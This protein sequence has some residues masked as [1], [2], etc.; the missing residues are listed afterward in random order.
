MRYLS[1]GEEEYR[2]ESPN[3]CVFQMLSLFYR[4]ALDSGPVAFILLPS[5]GDKKQRAQ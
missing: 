1:N 3:V 2:A 5:L 4:F